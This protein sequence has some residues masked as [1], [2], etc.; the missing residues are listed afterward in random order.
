MNF[1]LLV[2]DPLEQISEMVIQGCRWYLGLLINL[3]LTLD[4]DAKY[5][6]SYACYATLQMSIISSR[7]IP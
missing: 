3:F 4:S 1:G 5:E 6:N 7:E 2:F